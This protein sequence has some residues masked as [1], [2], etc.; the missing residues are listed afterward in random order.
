[1]GGEEIRDFLRHLIEDRGLS[2]NSIRQA[3]AAL[4][5]LY[6]ITLSRPTEVEHLLVQRPQKRVPVILSGSEDGAVLATT[7]RR[8]RRGGIRSA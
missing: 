8:H 2:R 1:M 4:T 7:R 6:S 3:R 5:F